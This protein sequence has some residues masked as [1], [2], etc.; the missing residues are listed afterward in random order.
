MAE[1]NVLHSDKIRNFETL[2]RLVKLGLGIVSCGHFLEPP[3]EDFQ[4]LIVVNVV[5][6]SR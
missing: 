4:D 2:E 1:L 5:R 6:C 3:Y